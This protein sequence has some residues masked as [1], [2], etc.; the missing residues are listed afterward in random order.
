MSG[1]HGQARREGIE[2]LES[3]LAAAARGGGAERVARQ[4][5]AGK[6]TARERV[7]LLLDPSSSSRSM[8][9]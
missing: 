6:L 8:R 7:E 1:P 9:W 2:E 5:A 4:H 3:R